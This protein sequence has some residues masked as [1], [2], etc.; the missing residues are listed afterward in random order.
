MTIPVLGSSSQEVRQKF[1]AQ[2][3]PR[4]KT[5]C[6]RTARLRVPMPVTKERARVQIDIVAIG[7]STGGPE[8]LTDL[9]PQFPADFPAPIAIVQHMPAKF[10][11][12]LAERLDTLTSLTVN[13]AQEGKRL[14][15]GQVWI[16]PGDYHMT[17]VQRQSEVVLSMNQRPAEQGCRP[18]VD[19]LFRSV[20]KTFGAH[21]LA[22]VLTGMGADGTS[23]AQA[24]WQAGGEVLVQD[25][26]SS[27]IWGMPGRIVAAGL[28]DC[29]YP[30]GS[31][32]SEIVRRVYARRPLPLQAQAA[33][34][35]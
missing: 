7:A 13:E 5:L 8:A 3:I 2:L 16:A 35:R 33:L 12:L 31:M 29:V 27:A 17:V 22:V 24:I 20:A 15:P 18:S 32:A 30:L 9:I 4:I 23:G 14:A 6:S 10:T 21:V 34:A 28:A 26:A 19:V 25:E 1:R 11:R